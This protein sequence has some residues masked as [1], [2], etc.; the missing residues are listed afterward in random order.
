MGRVYMYAS[1]P[2][3]WGAGSHI[4]PGVRPDAVLEPSQT[5]VIQH[6]ITLERAMLRD[7]GWA[8]TCGNGTPD[9]GEECDNGTANSDS[10]PDACRTTCL[11]AKCG[12]SVVDCRQAPKSAEI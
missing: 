8:T 2:V 3:V 9:L 5:P 4:E 7:L 10:M 1:N 11:R 12:D 6:D